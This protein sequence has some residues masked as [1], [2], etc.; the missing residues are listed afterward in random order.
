MNNR[1]A[2]TVV[3]S[4]EHNLPGHPENPRRFQHFHR[5]TEPPLSEQL[6]RVE[7][8]EDPVAAITSI[9]PP[10]Y[11]KE[12]EQAASRGPGFLDHGDTYVT[13]A[14]Y[15]SALEAVS[16]ALSVVNAVIEG[17]AMGGLA[18]VRPPGHHTSATRPSGFCLL[19]NIAIAARY[20]QSH[21][22]P[23]VAIVD[24]DVHHGNGTQAL[25]EK[26]PSV[27]YISTHQY[28]I[29]PGT[30]SIQETGL[31]EG[32]GSVVNIPLPARAGDQAFEALTIQV[33]EPI[34]ERFGPDILLISAGFDAHWNDPLASLQ[35][36]TT[37]Y[38]RLGTALSRMAESLCEGKIVYFLEG[39][40]DPDDLWDNIL[41]ILYSLKKETMP[42]D[43]LGPAPFPEA[44]VDN[45]IE[46]LQS[47]HGLRPK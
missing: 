25:F 37:G 46:T 38:N 35:M 4:P 24:F 47:I 2:Y 9:H 16:G 18:L 22:Y 45:L 32:K 14:S 1:I 20:A 43:R 28:G 27:L 13:S 39:G 6:L 19:N 29:Y 31:G 12:L 10:S 15:Q 40:Y 34:T 23:R 5:L 41:A 36:S 30:G 26:D 3:A 17:Q 42:A 33:I 11:L 8:H 7:P 21:G 44:N